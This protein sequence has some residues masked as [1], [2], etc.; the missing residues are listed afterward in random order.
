MRIWIARPEPGATRTARQ[1][2]D[3]GHDPLVAPVL[4]MVPT[5]DALPAGAFDGLVI[6]SAN[7]LA[8]LTRLG[9]SAIPAFCVGSRTAEAARAAGLTRIFDAQGDAAALARLVQESLPAGS[10]LL[11]LAGAERKAEPAASL[12]EAGYSVTAHVAYEM[13]AISRLPAPVAHDLGDR[14]LHAVLHYSRRS[15]E[16]A[17]ELA[18]SAGFGGAFRS[19]THYCLSADVAAPLLAGGSRLHVVA[20]R[21]SEESLLARLA[22]LGRDADRD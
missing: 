10:R 2:S 14:V 16:T 21:P 19:L 18:I 13:R 8:A 7:A 1:V 20:A 17:L 22:G 9:G 12:A 15:A 6:T 11:H 3:L 4:A 5:G